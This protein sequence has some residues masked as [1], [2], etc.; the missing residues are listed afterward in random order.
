MTESPR[1]PLLAGTKR[2]RSARRVAEAPRVLDLFDIPERYLRSVH[3]ERDFDDTASLRNYVVTPPMV[4][5]FARIVD[6]LRRG[7]GHRAWHITGDYG[8]GKSSFALMLAHLLRDPTAPILAHLRQAIDQVERDGLDLAPIRMVPILVTGAREALVPAVSHAIGRAVER[9]GSQRRV[10]RALKGLQRHAATVAKAGDTSQ[11]LELLDHL[12]DCAAQSGRSGVLLVLDELG[13]F[14]EY[15]ALHSDRED[16]YVLQRLAEAAVRSGDSPLV[17]LGL[18]HQGFHAYAERLPSTTRLEWD[19]V[20]G[21]YEEITLDQPLAHVAALVAGALNVRTELVPEDVAEAAHAMRSATLE[22]GWFGASARSHASLAP[23]ELY[24]LH[25]TVLPV[26]VRFFARFGQHER[27]LF[28][29]LLSSEPFGL[30]SFAE[31]PAS[32]DNWYRLPDFYDYVRSI[33]GHRLAG[34][35]Y[36]SHWLRMSGTLDRMTDV[37]A[38][39]LRVLKAVALLNVLDAEHLL[40]TDAVLAAAIADGDPEGAV[41]KA[42]VTLERRGVLF[43]RGAAGGYCLWP[44]TSINLESTIEAAHRALGPVDRVSAQLR[45]YLDESPVLA[46]RHYIE[47]GTLRHFE[48][49]YAEPTALSEVVARPT[50]ADGLL[51]VALCESPDE[52]LAA[53]AQAASADIASHPQVLVAVPPPLQGLAAEIQDARC[54]QWVVDHTPELAQDSYAAAEAARQIAASQR[55]LLK[56]LAALFGFHGECTEVEWWRLGRRLKLPERGRLS[57]ALS[58]ICDEVYDQ[59][60]RIRNELLNRRILSS[61]AAAA[62]FRLIER[63]F[64]AAD[65]PTLGIESGKAPP[66]KSMYLSVLSAGNVHRE[67]SGRFVLAEPP[68]AADPLQLRPALAQI[69]A[70]LERSDGDRVPVPKIFHALQSR[71]YGVRAGVAPLLLAIV[72]AARAHEIAVYEHGTFLPRFGGAESLR[73]IKQPTAFELQMCRVVGVRADVF[74]LLAH[75]FAGERPSDRTPELL[76]VVRPLS[77]FAAQLPAYTR[78]NSSLPEPARSV[79]DALL[80]AREP[81]TLIFTALP[82]ACGFEPFSA[83]GPGQIDQAHRFVDALRNVLADLRATY[84]DLL[85]RIRSRIAVGLGGGGVRPDLPQVAHRGSRVVLAAREPRLQTFA[86]CL[87]DQALPKDAWAERAGSFVL[88]KPPVQWTA[89]DETRAMDEIDLLAATFCRVEAAAFTGNG[90]DPDLTAIRVGFTQGD[91]TE[92][93]R[94]VRTRAEDEPRVQALAANLEA[95]LTDSGELRL[96][97]LARMLKRSLLENE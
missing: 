61:A 51:V 76:D 21:R 69:V 77:T 31:R 39:E 3:L 83:D 43:R 57:A 73:L 46:R 45:P 62:R 47:T 42:V 59:A 85:E 56:R 81:A 13:K 44:S 34:A 94:V 20:A 36:N 40:A 87:A 53:A 70:L 71:P 80:S 74:T 93:S 7:S 66:E 60:P 28:S 19:K 52:C 48:V 18:L 1:G 16:V 37:D 63:L 92:E 90:E 55:V 84:P 2:E 11:L 10:I 65:R 14:L 54:W 24:P 5:V 33:F 86:R 35:S 23:L 75:V 72:I 79:R 30:Q 41:G 32:G 82:I 78:I 67:E 50:E 6:G 15:A 12:R 17:V 88:S 29:F 38:L 22:T 26:M 49:R 58:A 89:A 68:E 9:L 96:A 8:T 4:T 27:S 91:G 95:A 64:S 97:V 25:P